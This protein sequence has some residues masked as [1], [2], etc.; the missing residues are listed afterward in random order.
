MAPSG[1][2]PWSFGRTGFRFGLR[3]TNAPKSKERGLTVRE[4]V[5]HSGLDPA[6]E[7]SGFLMLRG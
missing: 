1:K 2:H 6:H 5:A 4:W 3:Q 7:I